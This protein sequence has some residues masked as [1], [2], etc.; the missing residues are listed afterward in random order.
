MKKAKI[1]VPSFEQW[2]ESQE[3]DKPFVLIDDPGHG[4]RIIWTE[5]DDGLVGFYIIDKEDRT[6]K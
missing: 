1:N 2:W 4:K 3:S 6:N 5:G